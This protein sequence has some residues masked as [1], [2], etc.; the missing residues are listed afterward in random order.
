[1]G[2]NG[3]QNALFPGSVLNSGSANV[4]FSPQFAGVDPQNLASSANNL[5]GVQLYKLLYVFPVSKQVTALVFPKAET[6]DAFP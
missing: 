6:T 5:G 4:S 3:L 2:G 1:M